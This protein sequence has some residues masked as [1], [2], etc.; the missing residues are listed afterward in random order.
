MKREDAEEDVHLCGGLSVRDQL[1]RLGLRAQPVWQIISVVGTGALRLG[2]LDD[3]AFY[4]G[5]AA[6]VV[7]QPI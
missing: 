2:L 3:F 6:H 5:R 7:Q 1:Q 4:D